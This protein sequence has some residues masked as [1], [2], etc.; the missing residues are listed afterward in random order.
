MEEDQEE[1]GAVA[2]EDDAETKPVHADDGS[3]QASASSDAEKGD[4]KSNANPSTDN[5]YSIANVLSHFFSSG[6]HCNLSRGRSQKRPN[7]KFDAACDYF[8]PW[9]YDSHM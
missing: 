5:G 1:S 7:A 9:K 6:S 3:E 4:D 2:R 8:S